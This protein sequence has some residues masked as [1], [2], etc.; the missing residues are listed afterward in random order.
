MLVQLLLPFVFCGLHALVN[1][2][3]SQPDECQ[4]KFAAGDSLDDF[5]DNSSLF[6]AECADVL[7]TLLGPGPFRLTRAHALSGIARNITVRSE[8]ETRAQVSCDDFIPSAADAFLLEFRYWHT[9][10]LYGLQFQSCR[11]GISIVDVENV[12][13]ENSCFR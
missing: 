7:L 3:T 10:F 9:V 1:V 11:R 2:A 5:L 13:I 12:V 6:A 8:P 4:A